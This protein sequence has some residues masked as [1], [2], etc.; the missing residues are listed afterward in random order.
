MFFGGW[1]RCDRKER[2]S[3]K[4]TKVRQPVVRPAVA[5]ARIADSL[6]L[7]VDMVLIKKRS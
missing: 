1:E 6:V 7:D 2:T 5:V 3:T 4:E